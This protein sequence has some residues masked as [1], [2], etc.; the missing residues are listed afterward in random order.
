M[1]SN[2]SANYLLTLSLTLTLTIILT[3]T[4]TLTLTLILNLVLNL[5]Q[6]LI[7]TIAIS[8]LST[9]YEYFENKYTM[10]RTKGQEGINDQW[11]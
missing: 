11:K 9:V 7:V 8:C 5:T 10:R 2:I 1:H 4:L 6:I 3:L